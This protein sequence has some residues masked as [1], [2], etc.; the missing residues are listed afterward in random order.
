M[1]S[2]AVAQ[3]EPGRSGQFVTAA[4]AVARVGAG[5]I[6]QMPFKYHVAERQPFSIFPAKV[7][8]HGLILHCQDPTYSIPMFFTP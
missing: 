2:G 1:H 4:G 7:L 8:A 3:N 6:P 5:A